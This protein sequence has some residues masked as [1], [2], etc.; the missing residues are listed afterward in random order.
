MSTNFIYAYVVYYLFFKKKEQKSIF[1]QK[2]HFL[3]T[4]VYINQGYI[5]SFYANFFTLLK[6][7]YSPFATLFFASYLIIAIIIE[8]IDNI[9]PTAEP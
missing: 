1:L 6:L 2:R 8:A 4:I 9:S 3:T 7:G 5:L